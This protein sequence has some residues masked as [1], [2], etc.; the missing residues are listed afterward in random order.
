MDD[1]FTP[2]AIIPADSPAIQALKNLRLSLSGEG[3]NKD[4]AVQGNLGTYI[5]MS[6]DSGIEFGVSGMANKFGPYKDIRPTGVNAAYTSGPDTFAIEFNKLS[7]EQKQL[8]LNYI[9]QF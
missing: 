6:E 4:Y 7:P 5:P 1:N 8:M 9:R 3:M 2:V